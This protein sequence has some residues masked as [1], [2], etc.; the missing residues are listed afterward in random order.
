MA[1]EKWQ[2]VA[3]SCRAI[4]SGATWTEVRDAICFAFS[5]VGIDEDGNPR[6]ELY[7]LYL[8]C[9]AKMAGRYDPVMHDL[10]EYGLVVLDKEK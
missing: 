4:H 8:A 9:K 3:Q 5:G 6:H 7:S 10:A 1:S 2:E